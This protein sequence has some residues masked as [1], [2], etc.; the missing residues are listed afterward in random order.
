MSKL[1]EVNNHDPNH[2]VWPQT[3]SSHCLSSPY[4]GYIKAWFHLPEDKLRG[5]GRLLL[6][7]PH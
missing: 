5:A 4:T 3:L 6:G 2:K 7:V 1:A